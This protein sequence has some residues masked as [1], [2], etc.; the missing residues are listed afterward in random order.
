M[1]YSESV[2][3]DFYAWCFYLSPDVVTANSAASADGKNVTSIYQ[4]Q[5][6]DVPLVWCVSAQSESCHITS[7]EADLSTCIETFKQAWTNKDN[8]T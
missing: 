5:T 4:S 8:L 6:P 1:E 7:F 2:L 3:T